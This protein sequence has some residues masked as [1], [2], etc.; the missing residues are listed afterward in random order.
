LSR[1]IGRILDA[2]KVSES[3]ADHR[4]ARTWPWFVAWMI[5]GVGYAFGLI[6]GLIGLPLLIVGVIPVALLSR[7]PAS[8]RGVAGVCSGLGLVPAYIAFLNRAG[9]GDVCSHVP[10][11]SSCVSDEPLALGYCRCSPRCH[12]PRGFR[13]PWAPDHQTRVTFANAGVRWRP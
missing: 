6:E 7:R 1:L 13:Y 2:M 8:M 5:V 9:P 3:L 10:N 4:S 12:R 11:G